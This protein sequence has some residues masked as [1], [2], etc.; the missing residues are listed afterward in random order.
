M[1]KSLLQGVSL[2]DGPDDNHDANAKNIRETT[3]IV[4]YHPTDCESAYDP[5]GF[6][7]PTSTMSANLKRNFLP[8]SPR[9]QARVHKTLI[10]M[11][12]RAAKSN[13]SASFLSHG[14]RRGAAVRPK[15]SNNDFRA[16]SRFKPELQNPLR[17]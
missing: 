2:P 1:L 5:S 13:K 4:G 9:N 10:S 14:F 12:N 16:Y 11:N 17:A 6:V 3:T 7:S 8:I 15:S